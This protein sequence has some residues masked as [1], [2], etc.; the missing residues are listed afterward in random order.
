MS[1]FSCKL[2]SC[3][4]VAVVGNSGARDAASQRFKVDQS[5][6]GAEG[7]EVPSHQQDAED[8]AG[9]GGLGAHGS[10]GD[11]AAPAP[12]LAPSSAPLTSS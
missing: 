8:T 11:D 4:N 5:S 3:R 7:R 2:H 1:A 10:Q 9:C 6:C 12:W